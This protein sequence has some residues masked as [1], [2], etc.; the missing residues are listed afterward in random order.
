[1]LI[2]KRKLIHSCL[3]MF[4]GGW[5]GEEGEQSKNHGLMH[6]RFSQSKQTSF[7]NTDI[8]ADRQTHTHTH[9]PMPLLSPS[10]IKMTGVLV[11]VV[12][13]KGPSVQLDG[14][15]S[16]SGSSSSGLCPAK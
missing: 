1:M 7:T 13:L 16:V 14:G 5:G 11:E 8:Y 12:D 6:M 2:K 4:G 3:L 15:E 9:T 10:L